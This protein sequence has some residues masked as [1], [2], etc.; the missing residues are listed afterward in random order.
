MKLIP[1]Q[2]F[3]RLAQAASGMTLVEMMVAVAIGSGFR[4]QHERE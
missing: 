4:Y 2:M 1:T 3:P